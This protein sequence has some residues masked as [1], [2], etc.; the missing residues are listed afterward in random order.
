MG[1]NGKSMD[2]AGLPARLSGAGRTVENGLRM[3]V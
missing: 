3:V 1:A 2:P